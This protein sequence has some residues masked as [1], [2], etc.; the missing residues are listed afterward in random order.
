MFL[1]AEKPPLDDDLLM[2]FGVKGMRWGHRK[3]RDDEGGGGAR[4]SAP[5]PPMSEGKKT[6]IKVAVGVGVAAGAYFLVRRGMTPRVRALEDKSTKIGFKAAGR[7]LKTIGKVTVKTVPKV[8]KTTGK[9]GVKVG[10]KSAQITGRIGK[11]VGK[12]SFRKTVELGA[13]I[14]TKTVEAYRKVQA[15]R[16]LRNV[17]VVETGSRMA[18]RLMRRVGSTK[19]S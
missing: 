4:R 12:N 11:N 3:A 14:G 19:T 17:P 18:R 6:A 8:A 7:V 13:K 5:K 2:H 9:I 16:A 15:K 10:T 1:L